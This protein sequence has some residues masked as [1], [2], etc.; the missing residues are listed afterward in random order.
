[1]IQVRKIQ[2]NTDRSSHD[3][4]ARSLQQMDILLAD[5]SFD[6][7]CQHHEEDDNQIVVRHLHMVGQYLKSPKQRCHDESP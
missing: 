1:M 3:T 2:G 6:D 7:E 5:K 4:D